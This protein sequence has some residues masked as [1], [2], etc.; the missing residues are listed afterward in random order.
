[1]L[2][3]DKLIFKEGDTMDLDFV[4]DKKQVADICECLYKHCVNQIPQME[5]GKLM[6]IMNGS[7]LCNILYNVTSI[8]GEP[9]ST[10]FNNAC[11]DFIRQPKGDIDISYIPDR[12]YK[13]DL[14]SEEV[15]KFQSISEEQRTYNFVDHNSE[16]ED[17]DLKQIC[18]MTTKNGF[19]FYAK[20]PQYIFLYKFREFLAVFNKEILIND[21]DAIIFKKKN[22]IND[23]KILYSI[24]INYCGRDKLEIV[25]EELPYISNYLH[26]LYEQDKK[27]YNNLIVK[28]LDLICDLNII[29]QV[30]SK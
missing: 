29:K 2:E 6:W 28:S 24:A 10:S 17:N 18:K 5:N 27:M 22:I 13:F 26:N 1:M 9:V 21:I 14:E 19:S 30:K 7:T 20:K 3:T 25:L 16:L 11:Y 4:L 15:K 23:L 8:D 12:Q